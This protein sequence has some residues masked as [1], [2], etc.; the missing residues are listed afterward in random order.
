MLFL[1]VK[2]RICSAVILN[3]LNVNDPLNH[4]IFVG[5]PL[6]NLINNDII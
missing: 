4:Q 3:L 2:I 5:V 6:M 1:V